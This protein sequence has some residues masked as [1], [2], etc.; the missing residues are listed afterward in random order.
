MGLGYLT[1]GYLLSL[2]F[3]A[4]HY[5][6]LLPAL[7]LM[8]AG[9][10][11]LSVYN[12]PLREARFLLYPTVAVALLAF[13]LEGGRLFGAVTEGTYVSLNTY[14]SPV[15]LLLLALF[16]DRLLCGLSALAA[17]T[18][19][20]KLEYAAKRDRLFSAVAYGAYLF[21]SLPLPFDWY[22]SAVAHAFAPVLLLRLIVSAMVAYLIY[23][24]YMQICLPE[25]V[26]MPRKKTGISFLDEMNE[27][28]D[29]REE[30]RN[31]QK[32][33]ELARIYHEREAKYR[34]KQA[35]S[36]TTKKKGKKK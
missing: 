29:R 36:Q 14:L 22:A 3:F 27:K 31:A 25:D 5:L 19:L 6:T 2:N 11:K 33:E 32:K 16:T 9:M 20:P 13:L 34:E 35:N 21:C 23:S 15:Y 12:R 1:L 30:E 26:D 24:C 18:E 7:L 10:V 28:M 4:Y 8:F 17:E